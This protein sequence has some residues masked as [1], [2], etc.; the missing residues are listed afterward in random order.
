IVNV[1]SVAGRFGYPLFGWYCA[2][3]HALEG[4]SDALRNE[5]RPWK[6][7]VVLI[8]PGPVK[9]EFFDVSKAKAETHVADEASP[10]APFFR[11]IDRIEADFM[12]QATTPEGV[13]KVIVRACEKAKPKGRYAVTGMAKTAIA[14]SKLLPRS[15]MD[16]GIRKQFKIP[17]PAEVQ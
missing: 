2:T 9:T 5:V 16:A 12:K 13:A 7:R 14:A 1:S 10:Y 4:L 15:W 6:I 11:H 8:E 3:K 17:R